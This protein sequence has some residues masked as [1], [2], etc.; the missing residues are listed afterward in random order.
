MALRG[1]HTGG[2]IFGYDTISLGEGRG[3]EFDLVPRN[4]VGS[5][6]SDPF[7]SESSGNSRKG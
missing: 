7:D 6:N 5:E 3:E 2:R 4:A 1:L